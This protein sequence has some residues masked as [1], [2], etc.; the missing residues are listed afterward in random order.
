MTEIK[1]KR[2]TKDRKQKAEQNMDEWATRQLKGWVL[3]VGFLQLKKRSEQHAD[4][5]GH[6]DQEVL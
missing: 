4:S 1:D 2:K 5:G 3:V 6:A